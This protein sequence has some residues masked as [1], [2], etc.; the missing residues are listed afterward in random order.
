MRLVGTS[1][2]SDAIGWE[3]GPAQ[4]NQN[5]NQKTK[6]PKNKKPKNQKNAA[7]RSPDHEREV[8]RDR[9]AVRPRH[10][11]PHDVPAPRVYPFVT[12]VRHLHVLEDERNL[13]DADEVPRRSRLS[14]ERDEIP[15]V[16]DAMMIGR[17]NPRVSHAGTIL[18]DD[19]STCQNV[20]WCTARE[21]REGSNGKSS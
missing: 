8:V 15:R 21:G 19:S 13:S 2:G 10:R 3:A 6:K 5:Q 1:K 14:R 7:R 4:G 17:G 16:P 20:R 9:P 18:V 12:L 11:R